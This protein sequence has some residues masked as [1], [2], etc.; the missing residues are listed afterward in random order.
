MGGSGITARLAGFAAGVEY[1]HL[2]DTTVR[3]V[4]RMVLDCL[5]TTLAGSALGAGVER[6]IDLARQAGGAPEAAIV[7]TDVRAPAHLAALVN[8]GSA[9]ALNYDD[10]LP[11]GGVHLGV[12]GIPAC[13]AVADSAGGVSGRELIAAIA[14]GSE[15]MARLAAAIET[16]GYT[17]TRPQTSQLL[18][19]FNAAVAAGRALRLDPRQLH[20]ALG[21]AA[22]QC[23]GG[24]QPVLEG[25]EAKALYAAWPNQAGVQCA[26]LARSGLDGACAAFEGEAGLFATSF[27]GRY[28]P[29][30]LEAGLG[31]RW[32]VEGVTF[33]PWPTTNVAHVFIEAALALASERRVR[34][35]EVAAVHLTGQEHIRTFC[36]PA[37]TRQAPHTSVEAEDSIPFCTAKALANGS[38]GLADLQGEG[39]R[40][41]EALRIAA[42][43][44]YSTDA[45]L[46]RAG[47]VRVATA[48]GE[49][50]ERRVEQPLGFPPRELSDADLAAKFRD[51]ASHVRT[52]AS[53]DELLDQVLHLEDL[54]STSALTAG[55]RGL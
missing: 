9:H 7:G 24:R 1:A 5:A 27:Q 18:G 55:L 45:S 31:Q 30:A 14:A 6:L 12:T 37:A 25:A 10:Y 44:T 19:Y 17:E 16:G 50:L 28:S 43:T 41:P 23:S 46:G 29:A 33:K 8:G 11:G 32:L 54:A 52:A 38:L 53:T 35:E 47:I 3:A 20:S 26:L 51:C 42:V 48:S 49:R 21:L 2:P 39:L 4:K 15:V 22:M 13:L 36:E 40:Q 34:P